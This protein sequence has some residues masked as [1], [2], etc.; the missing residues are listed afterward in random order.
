MNNTIST[1]NIITTN[2]SYCN[3]CKRCLKTGVILLSNGLCAR[4]DDVLY[5]KK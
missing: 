5:G 3:C 4:C 1:T 2:K